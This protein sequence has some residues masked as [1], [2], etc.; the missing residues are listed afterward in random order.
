MSP[1]EE[2]FKLRDFPQFSKEA[3]IGAN[4]SGFGGKG[5]A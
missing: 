2:G 5:G 3:K 1:F 4:H